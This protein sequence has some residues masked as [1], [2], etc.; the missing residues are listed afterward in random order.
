MEFSINQI[1]EI[2]GGEI[3]GNSEERIKTI[4][5]IQEART[6]S[7]SFL[8][9][10]KY[11]HFLYQTEAS[12]II[13]SRDFTP[14]KPVKSTLIKV[15][16]PYVGFTLLLEEFHKI[17]SF[18]KTGVEDPAF[19][20]KDSTT[21]ENVY[22]GAF[23]YIGNHVR[24]GNNTKIYPQVYIGDNC[25]IGDNSII[26]PGVKIY[27]GTKIGNDVVLHSGAV[28]GSDGFGFAPQKDGSYKTIPQ[29]GNVVIHDRVSIGANTTIDCATL[30]NDSTIIGEG[31]KLDNLIMIA[32]NVEIGK[33]T[34]IAAQSGIS[35]STKLGESCV[36]AGQV[37][38][39]GHLEIANNTTV[40]AQAGIGKSV[41]ERGK[42]LMGSPA[43][44]HKEYLKVYTVFKKLPDLDSRIK[45]LEEKVL[46]LPT[47]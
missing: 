7:I 14:K 31:A 38:I 1:A 34:V 3:V 21:G 33:N 4:S 32:H 11:E 29:L 40:A 36:I 23:S 10:L 15:A 43:F 46:N 45:E 19:I 13:V 28:I 39:I 47:I 25:V 20:G 12:A 9:N 8:S 2:L 41:K 16:D 17:I 5:R 42:V 24:I 35:G 27:E 18:Q 22:R 6:G 30:L 26:H 44:D 37:G